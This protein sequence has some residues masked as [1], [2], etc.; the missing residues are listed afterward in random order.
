MFGFG[1]DF[2]LL[3]LFM[4]CLVLV[5]DLV[6]VAIGLRYFCLGCGLLYFLLFCGLALCF[7]RVVAFNSVAFGLPGWLLCAVGG[8]WLMFGLRFC[9]GWPC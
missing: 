3:W 6:L 9:D 2:V 5:L 4:I 8:L 1:V 7:F